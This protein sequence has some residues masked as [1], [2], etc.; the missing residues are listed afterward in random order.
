MHGGQICAETLPVGRTVQPHEFGFH[1][2]GCAPASG[3][4]RRGESQQ[5]YGC[6]FFHCGFIKTWQDKKREE[7]KHP[8][9]GEKLKWG[10]IPYI[11][12]QLLGRYLRGDLDDYPPF[13]WK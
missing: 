2:G 7:L 11:Q 8:Y 10:L 1:G 9:L 13:L 4:S 12:A 5:E 3:G 6:E